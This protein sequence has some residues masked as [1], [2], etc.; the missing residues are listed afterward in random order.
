MRGGTLG[1]DLTSVYFRYQDVAL[2]A[3]FRHPCFSWARPNPGVYLTARESFSLKA[4]LRQAANEMP[5]RAANVD[6]A[7][8]GNQR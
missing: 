4:F 5:A 6:S 1:P 8:G 7:S 3:F 2:T